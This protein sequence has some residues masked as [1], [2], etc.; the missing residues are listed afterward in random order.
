MKLLQQF[1]IVIAILIVACLPGGPQSVWAEDETIPLPGDPIPM[2]G[3]DVPLPG[4]NIPMPG[5][6][7]S[8]PMPDFRQNLSTFPFELRG[9]VE[10]TTSGEYLKQAE[11]DRIL[12]DIRARVDLS[13]TPNESLDFSIGVVGTMNQGATTADISHYLPDRIREQLVPDAE[14]FLTYQLES[15]KLFVQEAFGT[16][17]TD[18]FRLRVGRHKFYTG[19]G[20]AYNPIDLLNS[21]NP[22][23]PTYEAD[24]L[25]ALLLTVDLPYQTQLQGLVSYNDRLKDS[26][27]LARLKTYVN[28]W[29]VALQYTHHLKERIDWEALNTEEAL[30]DLMQGT[31]MDAFTRRFSWHLIGAEFAGELLGF[32]M[33]GEGGYVLV[34]EPEELG[35]LTEAANDH[36]RILVGL[37]RTFEF[38][39]YMM[40][41]YLRF[42]QG[43]TKKDELSLNDYMAFFSGEQIAIGRDTLFTGL[44]YPLT[45]FIEGSLYTIIN[46]NDGSGLLNPWL[47]YDIRPGL[48]LSASLNIPFGDEDGASGNAGISGFAR[49]KLNF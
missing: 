29:D 40:A 4:D 8:A 37:D 34:E 26:D 15:E 14:Q 30:D 47:V 5:E 6:N 24:G 10:N 12:N 17:Y 11:E 21:K 20:Y 27:Y 1:R 42:G 44:S 16:L 38:Q 3:D 32:G 45:D 18:H 33:Y 49:L 46:L 35:T 23:D 43:A 9:Y 19:T 2:P 36:E 13:G 48:K 22:L 28:G 41:E 39:L 31:S 25:D 7:E